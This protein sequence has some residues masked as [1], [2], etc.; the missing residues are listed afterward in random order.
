MTDPIDRRAKQAADSINTATSGTDLPPISSITRRAVTNRILGVTAIVGLVA[1]LI[2]FGPLAVSGSDPDNVAQSVTSTSTPSTATSTSEPTT[3]TILDGILQARWGGPGNLLIEF[4]DPDTLVAKAVA[5]F[6]GG[7][8]VEIHFQDDAPTLTIRVRLSGEAAPG[9]TVVV[10]GTP[11]IA[12]SDASW[13][14][15]LDVTLFASDG[16]V[17]VLEVDG[18]AYQIE[19]TLSDDPPGEDYDDG[20]PLTIEDDY[21]VDPD[22][23]TTTTTVDN[24]DDSEKDPATTTTGG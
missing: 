17:V 15:E 4:L 23:G 19:L 18:V 24:E 16:T 6:S 7:D 21:G 14:S 11:V 13:S 20:T 1:G 10:S 9:S 5:G 8:D 22:D 3:T 12:A 2:A